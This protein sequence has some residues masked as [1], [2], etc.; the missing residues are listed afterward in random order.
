MEIKNL[1]ILTEI[2]VEEAEEVNGGSA[3]SQVQG[4]I[5]GIRRNP[6]NPTLNGLANADA[7]KSGTYSALTYNQFAKGN[8][9]YIHSNPRN[10]RY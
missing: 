8:Y 5:G 2:N 6:N 9:R 1:S 7:Y 10:W 4:L 3:Y